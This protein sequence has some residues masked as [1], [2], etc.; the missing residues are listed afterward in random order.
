MALRGDP[1]MAWSTGH[2]ETWH[3]ACRLRPL[4]VAQGLWQERQRL[5]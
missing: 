4:W 3:E 2:T 1:G 5:L